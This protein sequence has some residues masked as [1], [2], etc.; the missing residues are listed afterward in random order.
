MKTRILSILLALSLVF[1]LSLVAFADDTAVKNVASE[2]GLTA[3]LADAAVGEI[4][5]TADI[6]VGATLR[7]AHKVTLDLAGT[8]AVFEKS[9]VAQVRLRVEF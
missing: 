8:S 2:A 7:V 4:K 3:A 6:T 5:L 9:E 1:G